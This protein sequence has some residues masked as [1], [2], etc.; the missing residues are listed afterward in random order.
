[1]N[2]TLGRSSDLFATPTT[3]HSLDQFRQLLNHYL[4]VIGQ[5]QEIL[6]S[7]YLALQG[8]ACL[9]LEQRQHLQRLLSQHHEQLLSFRGLLEQPQALPDEIVPR[10]YLPLLFL[11]NAESQIRY[12]LDLLTALPPVEQ[13]RTSTRQRQ[14]QQ[15]SFL[16]GWERLLHS[17]EELA[18]HTRVLSDQ[19]RFLLRRL[20]AEQR[21][22]RAVLAASQERQSDKATLDEQAE[23]GAV[24]SP[25]E[26]EALAESSL[27]R[28]DTTEER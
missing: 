7:E 26:Q 6:S 27:E 22:Q 23:S 19:T 10:R 21:E 12:L 13:E 2:D 5:Q 4:A 20:S 16:Q 17:Y 3:M 11:Q 14:R 15:Q 28:L 18:F 1:M 8:Q 9:R 24:A 25:G